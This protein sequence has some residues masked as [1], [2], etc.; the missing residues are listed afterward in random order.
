[1]AIASLWSHGSGSLAV[2]R[3]AG[4]KGVSP[5]GRA[6]NQRSRA[7]SPL[8][9]KDVVILSLGQPKTEADRE[10]STQSTPQ[11]GQTLAAFDQ[12]T[13]KLIWR[14][15]SLTPS[16]SSPQHISFKSQDQIALLMSRTDG[17]MGVDPEDGRLLWQFPF[18]DS[19]G[20]QMSPVWDGKGTFLCANAGGTRAI[21]LTQ[22]GDTTVPRELWH[23]KRVR[24]GIANP[25]RVGDCAFGA[26][27]QGRALIMGVDMNTG[28]RTWAK[29]ELDHA[30][31]V[32]G[33]GKTI[34][35]DWNGMLALTTTTAEG[36]TVHSKCQ[37]GERYS[38]TTPTLAG[39]TLYVR[40][41]KHIMALDL[42]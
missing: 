27:G 37:V 14:S 3:R 6:E 9:Y 26:T 22:V 29:S 19:F 31:C 1:M 23:S 2:R 7:A 28:K 4:P 18:T 25:I 24:F 8:A 39:T 21:K 13:G 10:P 20:N 40:D 32:V 33:G 11:A 34:F 42:R 36:L 16:H 12:A 30:S 41:R 15:Q 35:L 17:L 5:G 38:F